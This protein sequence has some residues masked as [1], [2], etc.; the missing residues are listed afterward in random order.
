MFN[1]IYFLRNVFVI[2]IFVVF[3]IWMLYF[4]KIFDVLFYDYFVL[5][6]VCR[7]NFFGNM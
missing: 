4:K 6:N 1:Y 7:I 3:F 2:F 5:I